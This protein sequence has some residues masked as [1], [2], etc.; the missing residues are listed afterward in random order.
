MK[1]TTISSTK[2]Y[3][4]VLL[5]LSV[6]YLGFG[7]FSVFRVFVFPL[8]VLG[9]MSLQDSP[10]ISSPTRLLVPFISFMIWFSWARLYCNDNWINPLLLV[11]F[12]SFIILYNFTPHNKQIDY[13][14]IFSFYSFPHIIAWITRTY[15]IDS[16]RFAGYHQ[17]PNFCALFLMI[18]LLGSLFVF[19]RSKHIGIR[20]LSFV[21][22][23]ITTYLLLFSG[24]RGALISIFL[25]L[26]FVFCTSEKIKPNVK[27]VVIVALVYAL[28]LL[29]NY[30]MSLPNWVDPDEDRLG[31]L[32][33]RMKPDSLLEG[34]SRSTVWANVLYQLRN[35]I[36]WFLPLGRENAMSFTELEF[37]HN[38]YLDFL[39]ETGVLVGL[40]VIVVFLINLAIDFILYFKK[41]LTR[42]EKEAFCISLAVIIQLFTL[43]ALTQKVFWLFV[44]IILCLKPERFRRAV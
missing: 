12:S 22:I 42:L 14:Y 32:L 16:G 7:Q 5:F 17:D 10:R 40:T 2:V 18:G 8:S 25:T 29:F 21:N 30:V 38:T 24:S 31:A 23:V 6:E 1:G 9:I 44:L 43:S 39:V 28:I 11:F 41:R 36:Y 13:S 19:V 27:V 26:L 3:Y 37:T 20:I 34:A 4:L 33:S 15:N 35:P